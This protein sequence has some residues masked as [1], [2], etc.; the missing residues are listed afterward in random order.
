M[1][2]AVGGPPLSNRLLLAFPDH[3]GTGRRVDVLP[4]EEGDSQRH[5]AG[6]SALGAPGRAEDC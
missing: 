4:R 5:K 2:L 3:G 1:L 6:E